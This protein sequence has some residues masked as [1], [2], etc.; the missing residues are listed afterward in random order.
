M[1]CAVGREREDV[2]MFGMA[3]EG[4]CCSAWHGSPVRRDRVGSQLSVGPSL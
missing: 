1:L 3:G 2:C 4:V